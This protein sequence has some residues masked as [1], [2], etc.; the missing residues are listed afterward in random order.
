VELRQVALT[1]IHR[2]FKRTFDLV[3]SALLLALCAPLMLAIALAVRLSSPGPVFFRQQRVGRDGRIFM[4]YKFRTMRQDAETQT[5]PVFARAGDPRRT[6][7]GSW[8]RAFSLDELPQFYNVLRGDMS[9]VGPRP[10]R[11]V[12]VQ[13]HLHRGMIRYYRKF[14]LKAYPAPVFGLVVAGVPVGDHGPARAE[15]HF[16]DMPVTL[17]ARSDVNPES[18]IQWFLHYRKH[19]DNP[20]GP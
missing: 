16:G 12:F 3:V 5:G 2:V 9:L 18:S 8:L 6:R 1:G 10:E 4:M 7:L 13:W 11:P 14:L 19:G 17:V 20:P 15:A